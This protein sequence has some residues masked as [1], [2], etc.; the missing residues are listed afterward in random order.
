MK[1]RPVRGRV[2]KVGVCFL[3]TLEGATVNS[4]RV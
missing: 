2:K 4:Q 1:P 3:D